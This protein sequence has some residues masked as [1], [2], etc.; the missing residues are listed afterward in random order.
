LII[1]EL[2]RLCGVGRRTLS[3][4][5]GISLQEF[6]DRGTVQVTRLLQPIR[7]GFHGFSVLLDE[8]ARARQAAMARMTL[9]IERSL[10]EHF[11]LVAERAGF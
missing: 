8:F 2:H 6:V 10:I 3:L 11:C 1:R 7:Y 9:L 4:S 5:R